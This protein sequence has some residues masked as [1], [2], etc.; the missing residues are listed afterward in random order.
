MFENMGFLA[1]DLQAA[2][3]NQGC[4]CRFFTDAKSGRTDILHAALISA[5]LKSSEKIKE[6]LP[7]L[8]TFP[9]P[10]FFY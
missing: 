6:R 1:N 7:F 2:A 8:S 10:I 5:E 4:A 3:C 9:F